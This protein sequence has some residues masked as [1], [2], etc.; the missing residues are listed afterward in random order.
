MCGDGCVKGNLVAFAQHCISSADKLNL[1]PVFFLQTFRLYNSIAVSTF[2]LQLPGTMSLQSAMLGLSFAA[3]SSRRRDMRTSCQSSRRQVR[4][5][6]L[7]TRRCLQVEFR[8]HTSDRF[9]WLQIAFRLSL[10]LGQF[11]VSGSDSRTIPDPGDICRI[12]RSC[13]QCAHSHEESC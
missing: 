13:W 11:F 12:G 8:V 2:H 6:N 4:C 10:S 5:K 7:S 3:A 1:A 9:R